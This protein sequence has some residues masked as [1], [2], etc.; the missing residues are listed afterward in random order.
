MKR[1]AR[2]GKLSPAVKVKQFRDFK[3]PEDPLLC[4]KE[5]FTEPCAEPE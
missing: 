2:R 5:P 3:V 1:N 4:P